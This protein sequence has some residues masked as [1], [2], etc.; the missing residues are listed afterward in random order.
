MDAS[1]DD[2]SLAICKKILKNALGVRKYSKELKAY[3]IE[4]GVINDTTFYEDFVKNNSLMNT[5]LY[6]L[7]KNLSQDVEN[8]HF[9]VG[10][11]LSD[12]CLYFSCKTDKQLKDTMA[13]LGEPIL[14]FEEIKKSRNKL[15]RFIQKLRD[16]VVFYFELVNTPETLAKPKKVVQKTVE[17]VDESIEESV[18]SISNEMITE[19]SKKNKRLN[20]E[21][22]EPGISKGML[23]LLDEY[24]HIATTGAFV[25][26]I[27]NELFVCN[28]EQASEIAHAY[29]FTY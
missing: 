4:K 26:L 3:F 7:A 19:N 13:T 11:K 14:E 27:D 23:D 20:S 8:S 15:F 1:Q 29:N 10:S 12:F 28:E 17:D 25:M 6:M 22:S 18:E 21:L 24:P 2:N 5:I 16:D 9:S